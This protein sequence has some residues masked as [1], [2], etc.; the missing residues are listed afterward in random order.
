MTL[1][2]GRELPYWKNLPYAGETS[3][4]KGIDPAAG[5]WPTFFLR[6][7]SRGEFLDGEGQ[8]LSF[9]LPHPSK[10]DFAGRE[11]EV[12]KKAL[13]NLTPEQITIAEYWGAGPATK[14]WTP[15][16]DRLVDTY[17]LSPAYAARVLAV[18]QAGIHDTFVVTWYLKFLWQVPRPNQLDP[19]L[20]TILCTPKFP[21]Y[22]SGHAAISGCAEVILSY[23][24]PAEAQKL[25]RLAEENAVSRIYAGVHFPADGS[26]GLSLGRQIGHIVV[27]RIKRALDKNGDRIDIPQQENRSAILIPPPYRQAIPFPRGRDC[28]SLLD[29]R[30]DPEARS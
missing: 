22:P 9:N 25:R 6:R 15:I 3:L 17:N 23:Y 21:A 19:K 24:F 28:S 1:Y 14:Q 30:E 10:I 5:S 8:K 18:V 13:R 29:P 12:V 11:L 4:P 20:R 7:N 27:D 16:I 26:G 2:S